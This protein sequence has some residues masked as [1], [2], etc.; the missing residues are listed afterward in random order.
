VARSSRTVT[1]AQLTALQVRDGGC[2]HPGCTRTAAFCDAHHV[3][4]WSQGGATDLSNLV[5]LC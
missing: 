3:Q 4:H 2:V 5:L 1:P